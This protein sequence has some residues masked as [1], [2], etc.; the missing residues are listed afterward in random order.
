MKNYL[1]NSLKLKLYY[2][3]KSNYEPERYLKI[4][5]NEKLKN[6]LRKIKS[7]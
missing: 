4:V 5:K 1:S 2:K 6:T 7:R 3:I